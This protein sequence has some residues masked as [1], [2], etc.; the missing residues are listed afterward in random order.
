MSEIVMKAAPLQQGVKV[1][2]VP[3]DEM[4][5]SWK[6]FKRD[7]YEPEMDKVA[8]KTGSVLHQHPSG[9]FTIVFKGKESGLK[10]GE[11][12]RFKFPPKA[13]QSCDMVEVKKRKPRL[14]K[15]VKVSPKK[16]A[17]PPTASTPVPA[18]AIVE[19]EVVMEPPPECLPTQRAIDECLHPSPKLENNHDREVGL[20]EA[21]WLAITAEEDEHERECEEKGLIE[22]PLPAGQDDDEDEEAAFLNELEEQERA[23]EEAFLADLEDDETESSAPSPPPSSSPASPKSS[24]PASPPRLHE[25]RSPSQPKSPEDNGPRVQV[26]YEPHEAVAV[27]AVRFGTCKHVNKV[28]QASSPKK[29][30]APSGVDGSP[31]RQVITSNAMRVND[32]RARYTAP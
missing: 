1:K 7:D 25:Y 30:G 12:Y 20:E 21:R 13:L 10:K 32:L 31:R 24:I 26:I 15:H 27:N 4:R 2:I 22:S 3:L 29:Q 28:G 17:A 19:P 16:K 9:A 23:E 8:G 11:S 6:H 18:M 14:P 5:E